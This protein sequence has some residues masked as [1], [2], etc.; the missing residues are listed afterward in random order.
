MI[1][2]IKI[3]TKQCIRVFKITKK[4]SK[5]EYKAVVK[6]SALGILLIGAIGF[7]VHFVKYLVN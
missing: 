2:K 4:P 5:D 1:D 7:V 3:F 6:I